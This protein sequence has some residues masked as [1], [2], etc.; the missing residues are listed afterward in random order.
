MSR[1]YKHR[2]STV[3]HIKDKNSKFGK[4]QA[5]AAVRRASDV[6]NGKQYRKCYCSWNISDY[7]WIEKK[8]TRD[9]F[10]R[11]WFDTA[12]YN[13]DNWGHDKFADYR[14]AFHNWREA[15]RHYVRYHKTK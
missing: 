4:R 15:Y 10:R 3:V 13:A 5:S 1:S 11:K 6:P 14:E 7:A 9:E 12:H 2:K 8:Y